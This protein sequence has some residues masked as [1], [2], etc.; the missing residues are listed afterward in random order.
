MG[1]SLITNAANA[2][3]FGN[4]LITTEFVTDHAN[5]HLALRSRG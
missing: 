4:P 2:S 3:V 5:I 1:R